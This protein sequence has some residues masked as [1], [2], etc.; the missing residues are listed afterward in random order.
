EG[1]EGKESGRSIPAFDLHAGIGAC[2]RYLLRYGGHRVAAG[3]TIQRDDVAAFSRSFSEHADA[4]LSDEDMVPLLRVDME[5][6]LHEAN[7]DMERWLRHF[8]PFG[9]GNPSPVF[10]SRRVRLLDR[11][12]SVGM[13]GIRL[14]LTD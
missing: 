6:P 8:E 13:D 9:I 4:V 10:V 7:D 5:I 12:R 14:R 2:S 3:L 1:G 11:P